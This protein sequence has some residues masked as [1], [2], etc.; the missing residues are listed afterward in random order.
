MKSRSCRDWF[1]GSV[2]INS[3]FWCIISSNLLSSKN[4]WSCLQRGR[5]MGVVKHC[6]ALLTVPS[7]YPPPLPFRGFQKP[8]KG[9]LKCY[10][11]PNLCWWLFPFKQ[12]DFKLN[13]KEY[14]QVFNQMHLGK[15][16]NFSLSY[17]RVFL[18]TAMCG[19]FMMKPKQNH[20][21]IPSCFLCLNKF[22]LQQYLYRYEISNIWDIPIPYICIISFE[23][24]YMYQS[25]QMNTSQFLLNPTN[26]FVIL[27]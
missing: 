7:R 19:I 21:K 11:S 10:H 15:N 17:K 2:G 25:F 26:Y 18:A 20:Y 8:T 13:I 12:E 16:I 27:T 4:V 9:R 5:G 24:L 14:I 1:S 6:V 3:V 23:C 22:Y